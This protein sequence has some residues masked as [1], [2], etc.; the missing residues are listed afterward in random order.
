MNDPPTRMI[1]HL[2]LD[3]FMNESKIPLASCCF[4]H[5]F[6]VEQDD[7]ASKAVALPKK[8]RKGA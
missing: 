3:S 4:V 1:L 8:T 6:K 5:F 7:T 2:H